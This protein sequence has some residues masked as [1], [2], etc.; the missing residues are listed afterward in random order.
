MKIEQLY[1][2]DGYTFDE[3]VA[4]LRLCHAPEGVVM[5]IA[6]T[7]N[8]SH[9]HS[10]IHK[11][12]RMPGTMRLLKE[13]GFGR[14][15]NKGNI[16]QIPQ[17]SPNVGTVE[18]NTIEPKSDK[19]EPKQ[20]DNEPKSD[21]VEPDS[22]D[23]SEIILTKQDVRK[24]ENTRYEDMPNDITRDLWLKRQDLYREMQQNHIKMR[25]VPKGSEHDEERAKYRA[26]VL[27][28][29]DEIDNIW[30]LIDAEIERFKNEKER[31]DKKANE[32]PDFDVSTYRSYISKALRKKSLT[33]AQRVE[34][35][36]RVDAMLEAKVEIKPET[37]E[38]LKAIGIRIE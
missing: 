13:K 17:N 32:R 20:D 18:S 38:K 23:P 24:H 14:E 16:P 5:H 35:Q 30:A 29:D 7:H 4:F 26:E 27:R 15:E 37:L 33:D 31:A 36:H 6:S 1:S 9:L 22:D 19:I 12:L 25:Q 3:G 28:L 34:L 21:K 11:Q 2:M 8:K 10:E